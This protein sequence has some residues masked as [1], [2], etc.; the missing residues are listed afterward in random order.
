VWQL[1]GVMCCVAYCTLGLY[2]TTY[3]V[4]TEM[5]ALKVQ[6]S[7]SFLAVFYRGRYDNLLL[8]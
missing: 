3:N 2:I 8:E 7:P 6:T 1:T 4:R 5:S